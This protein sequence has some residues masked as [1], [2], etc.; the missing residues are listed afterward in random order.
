VGS[1]TGIGQATAAWTSPKASF[2]ASPRPAGES[3]TVDVDA[4]QTTAPDGSIAAHA[5]DF[6]DGS[7][8]LRT[9]SASLAS[10]T[11][12][13]PG[14][15]AIKLS[16][17]DSAGALGEVARG[18]NL[19]PSPQGIGPFLRGDCNGDGDVTG[20]VTDAVSLLT[21]SR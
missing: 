14:R 1:P 5:W 8:I 10:H 4:S 13:S 3:L 20:Q 16:V 12:A 19:V 2:V 21:F 7:P 11:Y 18:V 6:G 15:Y 17:T 9:E